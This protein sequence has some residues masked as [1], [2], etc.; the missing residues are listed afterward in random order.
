MDGMKIAT[1]V[2]RTIWRLFIAFVVAAAIVGALIA[3]YFLRLVSSM[4]KIFSSQ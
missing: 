3:R 2:F 4:T 1:Q